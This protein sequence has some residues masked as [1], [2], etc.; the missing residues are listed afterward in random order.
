MEKIVLEIRRKF[1]A[2]KDYVRC[3]RPC[4]PCDTIMNSGTLG[5]HT[6]QL[7]RIGREYRINAGCRLNKTIDEYRAHVR[8]EYPNTPKSR[9]TYA[10]LKKFEAFIKDVEAERAAKAKRAKAKK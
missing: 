9:A 1:P 7:V 2:D 8:A 10:I 5:D 6:F 4:P 3:A